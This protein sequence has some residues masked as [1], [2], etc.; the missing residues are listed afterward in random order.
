[1]RT[2]EFCPCTLQAG[3]ATYSPQALRM[4][5]GVKRKYLRIVQERHAR[6]IRA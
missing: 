3:Y 2:I 1:M 6:F 4:L 5:F